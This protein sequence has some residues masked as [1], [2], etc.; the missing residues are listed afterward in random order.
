MNSPTPLITK[1]W[2]RAVVFVLVFFAG[3]VSIG[4]VLGMLTVTTE[5]K[6]GNAGDSAAL[7][8]TALYVLINTLL[9][10]VLTVLFRR[11]VDGRPVASLGFKWDHYQHHAATGFCL[12]LALLG[13]G[14]LILF[15]HKNL[16]WNNVHVQPDDLFIA[17]VL[18]MMVA[19]GEEMV[20][21]GYI[22]RNLLQSMNKWVALVI[23]ALLFVMAHAGNPG[24]TAVAVINLLLGG[25]LLG[26]NYIYT[27]NLW[28][29]LFFHLGWNYFQG[30]V[31]G[32]EVS[33]ISLQSVLEPELKGPSWLTGGQ[34][35]FEGSIAATIVFIPAL[36][37]LYL[38]YERRYNKG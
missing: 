28:Y 8:N 14:T 5:G 20:F 7:N 12:S 21:R 3:A 9:S 11:Y 35:G 19:L 36:V 31:L 24:M 33:G 27:R 10:V 25:L 32:Y 26:I 6:A 1:G 18:M 34:F 22:L 17:L 15:F 29:A 13:T 4:L 23:S 2:L 30:P 38:V 16:Q 37:I